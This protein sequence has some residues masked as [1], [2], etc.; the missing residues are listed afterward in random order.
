MS[1]AME[2]TTFHVGKPLPSAQSKPEEKGRVNAI[3]ALSPAGRGPVSGPRAS[4]LCPKRCE[5]NLHIFFFFR[6]LCFSLKGG[7]I[8]VVTRI[9]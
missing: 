9:R 1:L 4:P 2:E 8:E 3:G 7:L 6:S 5:G